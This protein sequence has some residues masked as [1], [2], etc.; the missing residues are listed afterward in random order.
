MSWDRGL[1]EIL[2]RIDARAQVRDLE[3]EP[4]F[5]ERAASTDPLEVAAL[6]RVRPTS[7]TRFAIRRAALFLA[8]PADPRIAR[9]ALDRLEQ[10]YQSALVGVWLDILE[11]HGDSSSVLRDSF[12]H[13]HDEPPEALR[14]IGDVRAVLAARAGGVPLP[15][16]AEMQA[17]LAEDPRQ[18]SLLAEVYADPDNLDV[19]AVLADHLLQLGDP[20]GEFITIGLARRSRGR[21]PEDPGTTRRASQLWEAHAKEWYTPLAGVADLP[22]SRC[23]GGFLHHVVCSSP[24]PGRPPARFARPHAI[25]A[26]QG[27]PCWQTVR[28]IDLMRAIAGMAAVLLDPVCRHVLEVTGMVDADYDELRGRTL[29]WRKL[30]FRGSFG[31]RR[32]DAEP[33]FPAL[34]KVVLYGQATALFS[35][36]PMWD[37][38]EHLVVSEAGTTDLIAAA[39]WMPKLT[40]VT[41]HRETEILRWR[42]ELGGQ[43]GFAGAEARGGR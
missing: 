12:G 8:R 29:P 28:S 30:G 3:D 18:E 15:W 19:R 25:L 39:G 27:A 7:S 38:V 2:D 1:V 34:E 33:E 42:R 6:C 31:T 5:V 9:W 14:R 16:I 20:R 35:R 41:A 17:A 40:K 23:S 11:K 21:D 10:H 37:N 24:R 26:A 43:W 32:P 36:V 22:A 4:D 13:R